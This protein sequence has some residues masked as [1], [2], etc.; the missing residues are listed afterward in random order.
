MAQTSLSFEFLFFSVSGKRNELFDKIQNLSSESVVSVVGKV[1]LRPQEMQNKAMS[2][3]G[4][5][6]EIQDLQVLNSADPLPFSLSDKN[7][8]ARLLC[9]LNVNF[10][11]ISQTLSLSNSPTR[12]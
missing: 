10:V 4:V 5:E 9:L 3:G 8:L 7:K 6:I 12:P 11:L 2:T 1:R